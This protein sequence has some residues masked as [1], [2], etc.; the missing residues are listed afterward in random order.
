MFK[1]YFKVAFRSLLRNRVSSAI[2]IGGL[3]VGMTVAL[4]IGFWLWD[5]LSFNKSFAHYHRITQIMQN[6]TFNGKVETWSMR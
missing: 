6:Q 2:N 5:E 1:N 3:A 4:L